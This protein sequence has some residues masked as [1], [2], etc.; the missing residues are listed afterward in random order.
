[1]REEI[2]LYFYTALF[3]IAPFVGSLL[4]LSIGR[5]THLFT[6]PKYFSA[7][8]LFMGC[9]YYGAFF[10]GE[11]II[12]IVNISLCQ[13]NAKAMGVTGFLQDYFIP[14]LFAI[15]LY[16]LGNKVF[17]VVFRNNGKVIYSFLIYY[18][19]NYILFYLAMQPFIN[20]T[21]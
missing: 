16:I 5:K 15:P 14:L 17:K 7:Y 13:M 6:I 19:L 2:A 18:S 21:Y 3:V 10:F 1:M 9:T 8:V 11:K 4:G 20:K 12:P